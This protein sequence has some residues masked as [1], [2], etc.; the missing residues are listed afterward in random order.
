MRNVVP[1]R[2]PDAVF[3]SERNAAED[4]SAHNPLC[5]VDLMTPQAAAAYLGVEVATLA[6]WRC[7]K[8][9]PL[10]YIKVGRLVHY[11]KSHLDAFLAARTVDLTV[12]GSATAG[13]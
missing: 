11:R 5:F 4:A 13:P 2:Q 12:G 1:K 9:Y 6:M 7:T 8:R 3:A 10:P